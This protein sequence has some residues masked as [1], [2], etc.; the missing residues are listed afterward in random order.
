MSNL[1]KYP[2]RVVILTLL[3]TCFT[4][5]SGPKNADANS[6]AN[7]TVPHSLVRVPTDVNTIEAAVQV[8]SDGGV[9]EIQGGRYIS[10][11]GP[12]I[13]NNLG[14]S[15]TM[16][17]AAGQEVIL[18]GNGSQDI[19]RFQNTPDQA[20]HNRIVF[21]G[22]TFSG[23][24]TTTEGVAAGVTIHYATAEFRNC[25]FVD[26]QGGQPT[27]G[28]GALAIG[29]NSVVA[30]SNCSFDANLAKNEGGAIAINSNAQ[31][32]IY[33][34]TFTNNRVDLPNHRITAA[35]GAVHIGNSVVHITDSTFTG[36]RAGY[37]GGALFA[38]GTWADNTNAP[39]ALVYI[40]GSTFSQ[41]V[42][43]RDPSVNFPHPTEGGGVHFEDQSTGIIRKSVFN[44]NE[45][46]IGAGLNLYR[47]TVEIHESVFN[48]NRTTS[49][50]PGQGFGAAISATSNDG[51]DSTTGGGTINRPSAQ[52]LVDRTLIVGTPANPTNAAN[53]IFIGGDQFRVYGIGVPQMGTVAQNRGVA[54]ITNSMFYD[55]DVQDIGIP[56]TGIGGGLAGDMAHITM[57][58]V[59]FYGADAK[60]NVNASGGA[61][62]LL[63]QSVADFNRLTVA[64]SSSGVFGGG[65]FVQGST[66]DLR[67]CLLVENEVSPGVNEGVGQS[68]GAALFSGPDGGRQLGVSGSV[69]NCVISANIGLPIYDDDRQDGTIND[70]RYNNNQIYTT[71][72]GDIA[73]TDSIA[74]QCCKT[75]AELNAITIPRNV[76]VPTTKKSQ[77]PNTKLNAKANVGALIPLVNSPIGIGAQPYLLAFV[78]SGESA[79]LDGVGL[80]TNGGTT[81]IIPPTNSRQSARVIT[82][83]LIVGNETITAEVIQLEGSS[84]FLPSIVR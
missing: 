19:L 29:L 11:N 8:V 76:G 62:A 53:G 46:D 3:L 55:T 68:F 81:Q 71:T 75:V 77:T 43:K 67:N 14:K 48:G 33:N 83:T 39:Q 49:T 52:L 63:N 30:L 4:F 50:T 79:T 58:N 7:T 74:Y 25:R 37:V 47:A 2:E 44:N 69:S 41:N 51:N 6:P 5:I 40:T 31:V 18:L 64:K 13:L 28:G 84:L 54:T 21:D 10:T 17:A 23:G 80:R 57:D 66:M 1:Q 78:W 60:G 20:N 9:I 22:L 42:A 61:I 45:A 72:F 56:G 35:G 36:N 38:I 16:Q 59:I 12:L 65:I 73:Y 82:H 24:R 34:S 32:S 70:M 27:T 26:N 15:F